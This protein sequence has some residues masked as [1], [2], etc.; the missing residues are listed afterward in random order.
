MKANPEEIS[1][2]KINK[3]KFWIEKSFDYYMTKTGYILKDKLVQIEASLL[4]KIIL[5]VQEVVIHFI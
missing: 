3:N 4:E 2:L 1:S 5:C